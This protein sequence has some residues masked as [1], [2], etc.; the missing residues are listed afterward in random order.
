MEPL[1]KP[2]IKENA[3]SSSEEILDIRYIIGSI[4]SVASLILTI[5]RRRFVVT[6]EG[7]VKIRLPPAR[8]DCRCGGH[9]G[10]HG[11]RRYP[12]GAASRRGGSSQAFDWKPAKAFQARN[13][14]V[15]QNAAPRM[16]DQLET[17]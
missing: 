10:R 3:V 5:R 16:I 11:S 6:Y 12:S 7:A 8:K 13:A 2:I 15:E 1:F 9:R 17:G 14:G 4:A